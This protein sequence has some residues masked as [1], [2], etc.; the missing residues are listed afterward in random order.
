MSSPDLTRPARSAAKNIMRASGRARNPSQK[1]REAGAGDQQGTRSTGQVGFREFGE[2]HAEEIEGREGEE[3][4]DDDEEVE[5]VTVVPG[6][7]VAAAAQ[8][9]EPKPKKTRVSKKWNTL[10]DL[11]LAQKGV[12]E[13]ARERE[14][15][16]FVLCFCYV[17]HIHT[18][19]SSLSCMS[20]VHT[21]PQ[22]RQQQYA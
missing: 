5:A 3:Q 18:C 10:Y 4:F 2:R 13:R 16:P 7:Q 15:S 11:V 21:H 9:T 22:E 14:E 1:A 6:K 19:R 8:P 17:K 12:R 20:R